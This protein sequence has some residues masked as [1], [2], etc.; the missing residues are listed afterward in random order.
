MDYL[1]STS[2]LAVDDPAELA[3]A[4]AGFEEDAVGLRDGAER[5][6]TLPPDYPTPYLTWNDWQGKVADRTL[7]TLGHGPEEIEQELAACFRPNPRYGGQLGQLIDDIEQ[8]LLAEEWVVVAS[9]QAKRLAE[10]WSEEHSPVLPVETLP[11]PPQTNLTFVQGPLEEGWTL[12]CDHLGAGPSSPLQPPE[13]TIPSALH[14]LTD[15]EIFGWRMPAPRRTTRRRRPAPESLYADLTP[16]DIVVH[17]DYGIGVFRGLENYTLEGEEREYLLVEYAGQDYL[18]VP[19]YQAD[20]LS[21]YVGADERPPVLS[22]LGTAEWSQVKVRARRAIE[23]VAHDLLELYAIREVTQG[24]AFGP[25]TSWQADLEASFPY[26]ETPDQARAIA[27]VKADM[28]LPRPMDRLVCGDVGYGK[29]EVA[30]RAAFKAAMD[31]K[32]VA[33]LVPTTVLAQQHY[34]TFRHRLAPFPITVEHLSRFRTRA[35]QARILEGLLTG[36]VDIV[37]GT[38]RLLQKDVI[39]KDLGL[40]IIDEEQRFGVTHK[41]RLKKMRT[42]VDVL[43]MTATPIPRT[44]YLSLTGVRDISVIETPPEE[45]LPVATYVGAY[46]AQVVRRS[47]LRELERSGQVFYVHNRVQTIEATRKRLEQLLPEATFGVA[48]GQMRERDLERAMLQF[49]SG[50]IDV[51]LCTSIIESGLDIPNANTLIVEQAERFGLAQLYQLRGRVGRGAQRA[52][53]YFFYSPGRLTAEARQRLDAIREA[54]D[55]GAGYSVAM[56]D[57]ELRGAG[58]VLGTRQSGHIAAIGFDL[59]TRLLTRAV[60]ELRARRDNRPPPPEPLSSIRID[61]PIVANLPP[62][63]VP[64]VNLRLR[65][66]RRLADLVSLEQVH[67]IE[68]ELQDRFGPLP[69]PAQNLMLQLQL[70][71]LAREAGV[72]S[73]AVENERIVLSADWLHDVNRRQLKTQ[74][75]SLAHLG[76]GAVSFPMRED[77]QAQLR[78]VL[79]ILLHGREME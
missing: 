48:H 16:G 45:R 41:E 60:E 14:V 50:E 38:H 36:Q 17:V 71:V 21:R 53:A 42:E 13:G 58:D 39:F 78:T 34:T 5:E 46:G 54:S 32:Q 37:I 47:I 52:Y 63:Y 40:V 64:D 79:E 65:L 55:L 77:W 7:L 68:A 8:A 66:Y 27:A 1:P 33:I 29:T 69:G 11:A 62:A 18:Y 24:H 75:R 2:V 4:W 20:R 61:L 74:L 31:G 67:E 6:G 76:R 59:Y 9:R 23:A 44:L 30:L 49:V 35:E 51:L 56:R 70:K 43:T 15:G 57:L 28:E 72:K 3:E 10:L 22:R 73:I 19:I 25:D 12:R 26:V